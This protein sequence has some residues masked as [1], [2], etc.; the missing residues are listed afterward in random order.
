[1]RRSSLFAIVGVF[2]GV[3]VALAAVAL[4]WGD[5]LAY[6]RPPEAP[7]SPVAPP[8]TPT[9]ESVSVATQSGDVA[10]T[11]T[12]SADKIREAWAPVAEAGEKG[13]YDTWVTIHDADT[14]QLLFAENEDV[15]HRPAST[16]KVLTGLFALATLDADS[17]LTTGVSEEGGD[18]YLWGE[19]DLLLAAG[20]GDKDAIDGHAG[21]ADLAAQV[22][23]HL[24]AAGVDRVS[25]HYQNALF[26]GEK[27]NP[28]WV[29]QENSDFAGDVGPFAID[30]GRVAPLAWQ[31]VE[32]SSRTTA[33]TLAALLVEGGIHVETV[34]PFDGA[35]PVGASVIAEV[36]SARLV[37]QIG[38]MLATSDNTMAEQLCH[39]AAEESGV[40][41]TTFPASSQALTSF[42]GGRGVSVDGLNVA[43]CSGLDEDSRVSGET[44]VQAL[45]STAGAGAQEGTLIRLL[46][47]GGRTGTLAVRFDE[48]PT[49]GN[50]V[51]KTG[52]LGMVAALAGVMT[53]ASGENLV[54]AVG[55]DNVPES[56]GGYSSYYFDEFLKELAQM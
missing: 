28:G 50:V 19:G 17:T 21:L 7:N 32:D 43:D 51:A 14:G 12:I 48:G 36:E 5:D 23:E 34:E 47:I 45:Q 42:L 4:I 18:L 38:F 46:P 31:F 8:S 26:A 33:D 20:S 54:F 53:T 24:N 25:L 30:T 10:T 15:A 35:A 40:E 3:L 39:L 27:R 2:V 16:M 6:G 11:T 56:A 13:G 49:T 55:T 1:M 22:V 52:T 29:E 37:D 44:L 41:E 9:L